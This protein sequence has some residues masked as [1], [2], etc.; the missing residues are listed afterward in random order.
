MA[1]LVFSSELVVVS[2]VIHG[3]GKAALFGLVSLHHGGF[4]ELG[5]FLAVSMPSL[6]PFSLV[7]CIQVSWLWWGGA[8][9]NNGVNM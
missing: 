2:L 3:W 1:T 9:W 6:A 5:I 7:L 8:L 4:T